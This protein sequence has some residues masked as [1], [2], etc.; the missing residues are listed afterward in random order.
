MQHRNHGHEWANLTQPE[1]RA[2]GLP[3][4][5]APLAIHHRNSD[6]VPTVPVL[7]QVK[8]EIA[9]QMQADGLLTLGVRGT[10]LGS[11][12]LAYFLAAVLGVALIDD[13]MN[14]PRDSRG[15]V[16]SVRG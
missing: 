3:D 9:K 5:P 4:E 11:I 12:G 7:E 6:L 15:Y 1:R 13:F 14:G 10:V 16:S 2:F 8:R